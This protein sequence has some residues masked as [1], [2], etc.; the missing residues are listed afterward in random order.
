MAWCG[1]AKGGGTSTKLSEPLPGRAVR[2][3]PLHI[4]LKYMHVTR[5]ALF[6]RSWCLSGP[7]QAIR[8]TYLEKYGTTTRP[9]SIVHAGG[10]SLDS[11]AGL[12]SLVSSLVLA[13]F[14][15][16]LG[17]IIPLLTYSGTFGS[18]LAPPSRCRSS[19]LSSMHYG[20]MGDCGRRG[21]CGGIGHDGHA[22][23]SHRAS[24]LY[25]HPIVVFYC[26]RGG[27]Y[28][29]RSRARSPSA[30]LVS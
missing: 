20:F 17:L 18:T 16:S 1:W 11:L 26:A 7:D 22:R 28:F 9:S 12:W 8:C 2:S 6:E 5:G 15:L 23:L 30:A 27:H 14:S 29:K 13:A 3:G 4:R 19:R 25:A 10:L 21:D 24:F